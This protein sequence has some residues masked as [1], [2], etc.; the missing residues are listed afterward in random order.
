MTK[1][2]L[3]EAI[4]DK[5]GGFSRREAAALVDTIFDAMKECLAEGH[6]VKLSGFGNFVLRDKAERTGQNPR[7]GERITLPPRRVVRFKPSPLL[8][9]RINTP[10]RRSTIPPPRRTP[11]TPP[12][13]VPPQTKPPLVARDDEQDPSGT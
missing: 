9:N 2:E 5:V 8:K 11:S 7:T 3:I 12:V 4:C 6:K 13:T 10:P 1:A